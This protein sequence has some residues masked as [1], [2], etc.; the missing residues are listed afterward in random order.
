MGKMFNRKL[1]KRTKIFRTKL[2]GDLADCFSNFYA[3]YLSKHRTNRKNAA[4]KC[5]PSLFV[6]KHRLIKFPR[7]R[8]LGRAWS[9]AARFQTGN[10]LRGSL[11][12]RRLRTSQHDKIKMA[13]AKVKN[14]LRMYRVKDKFDAVILAVHAC[15]TEKGFCC[16]GSGE[17]WYFCALA[18]VQ[19]H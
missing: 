19:F 12:T 1:S 8:R 18:V 6:N 3:P 16:V 15:L 4:G 9:H 14:L 13:E 17:V 10:E 2:T 7:F 11:L 5:L